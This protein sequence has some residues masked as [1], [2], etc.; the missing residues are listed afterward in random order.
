MLPPNNWPPHWG[1]FAVHFCRYIPI[2]HYRRFAME[3][4]IAS[5][6]FFVTLLLIL[7]NFRIPKEG[8]R[9]TKKHR[10]DLL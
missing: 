5:V 2:L 8:R 1:V 9:R 4:L 7:K 6:A 3:W 10:D